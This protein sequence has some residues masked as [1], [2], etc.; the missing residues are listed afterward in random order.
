MHD[1]GAPA[2]VDSGRIDEGR[3]LRVNAYG[4]N[5]IGFRYVQQRRAI[6]TTNNRRH[7]AAKH[8]SNETGATAQAFDAARR[9]KPA[10]APRRR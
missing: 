9:A 4:N 1:S 10:T 7:R 2:P 3:P 6:N 8:S 5:D